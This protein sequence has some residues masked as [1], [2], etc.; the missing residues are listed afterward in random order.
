MKHG[1]GLVPGELHDHR[2]VNA[3]AERAY[4]KKMVEWA[5]K[6]YLDIKKESTMTFG[7]LVEWYLELPVVRQNKTI[8]D[9]ERACRD[10]EKVYGSVLI[11]EIK[12]GMVEEYQRQRL[13]EPTWHGKP[14]SP[15]NVNRTITVMKHMFNL[16]VPDG[17]A[18]KNPCWKVK[19]LQEASARDRILSPEELD[20]LLQ[21]LPR[22]A[23]LV[24]YFAYL[25]GMR[26]REI[27]TLAWDKV[28][29]ASRTVRLAAEDT[30]RVG[31]SWA[32]CCAF[33]LNLL[34]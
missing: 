30:K 16:A 9:I 2:L 34:Y 29:L 25:T 7:Q 33:S 13:Q 31:K 14:R 22:H 20:R 12:P 19:L 11:R 24:V 10:L 6:K 15:A 32:C 8:K 28:D 21:H 18:D 3:G 27:F 5:E 1:C 17:L 4:Q 23:A 26:A